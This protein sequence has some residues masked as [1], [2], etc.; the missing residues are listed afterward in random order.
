M[1]VSVCRSV[2]IRSTTH[3]LKKLTG[4]RVVEG[5]V[6]ILL[7]DK[8]TPED[9]EN[10]TFPELTEITGFLL[11]YRVEGLRSLST[12]FPNLTVIRGRDLL[13]NHAFIIYELTS[14]QEVG[15][16]SLTD[17][18]RG[19]V[20]ISK[21]PNLCFAQSIDWGL[22]AKQ[23]AANNVI[24]VSSTSSTPLRIFSAY[25]IFFYSKTK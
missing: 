14:I 9:F 10:Y 7:L 5:N 22:I 6:H 2:D 21:N 12:L 20:Y 13:Y 19:A 17:I 15:L 3:N 11:L 18:E 24:N 4:C 1:Y 23:G 25:F 8:T 16:Y